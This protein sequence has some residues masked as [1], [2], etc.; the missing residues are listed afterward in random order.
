LP[1]FAT[2]SCVASP[3]VAAIVHR[4]DAISTTL[5]SLRSAELFYEPSGLMPAR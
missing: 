5:G 1:S 3:S 2:S 4:A